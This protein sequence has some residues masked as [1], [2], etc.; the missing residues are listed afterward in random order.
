MARSSSETI[1]GDDNIIMVVSSEQRGKV[2]ADFSGKKYKN[3]SEL[4]KAHGLS[5]SC[6][7]RILTAAQKS[8]AAPKSQLSPKRQSEKSPPKLVVREKD[9]ADSDEDN[10]DESDAESDGN[11]QMRSE[12]FADDLGLVSGQLRNA[13][14]SD[15]EDDGDREAKLEAA[16]NHVVG[17]GSSGDNFVLPQNLVNA[18]IVAFRAAVGQVLFRYPLKSFSLPT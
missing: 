14:D 12:R 10:S 17:G 5:R 8:K 13:V 6:V 3:A 2:L 16:M 7:Y 18:M 11:F 1:I 4:A 15:D 9:D